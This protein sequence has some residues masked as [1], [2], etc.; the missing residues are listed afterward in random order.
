LV[1]LLLILPSRGVGGTEEFALKCLQTAA[2]QGLAPG[3]AVPRVPQTVPVIASAERIGAKLYGFDLPPTAD[4]L[5]PHGVQALDAE[6]QATIRRAHPDAVLVV[7]P[8]AARAM[9]ILLALH[10]AGV[11]TLVV[12]QLVAHGFALGALDPRR[13]AAAAADQT[14]VA[15]SH[16]NRATL[17]ASLG[18]ARENV[19]VAVNGAALPPPTSISSDSRSAARLRVESRYAVPCGRTLLLLVGRLVPQKG[20]DVVPGVLASLLAMGIDC[21]ALLAGEGPLRGFV[22]RQSQRLHVPDR[23]TLP[24]VCRDVGDL[25]RAADVVLVPS[26]W[27]GSSLALAEALAAGCCIAASDIPSNRETVGPT[28]AAIL[29]VASA[30]EYAKAVY[31]I[32]NDE[33]LALTLRRAARGRA[34][35]HL[36]DAILLPRLLEKIPRKS[37]RL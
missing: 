7:T 28:R 6:T 4:R 22:E 16:D 21:H 3:L 23:V 18:L 24:G 32:V 9:P 36:D 5:N 15:V 27:E 2:A 29:C 1:R 14:W 10:S 13:V 31:R 19:S 37:S 35:E 12:F 30:T 33:R 8:A 17:T 25:L 20:T 26:R 11:P 34:A